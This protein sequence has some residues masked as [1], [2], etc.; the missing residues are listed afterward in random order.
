M[1]TGLIEAVGTLVEV[2]AYGGGLRLRIETPFAREMAPGHSLAV[3]GVCLTATLIDGDEVH[4]DVGPETARVTTLADLTR[5]QMVNLERS[6][7]A[8]GRIGGHFVQGHVDGVGTI[9]EVRADGVSHWLTVSYPPVLAPYLV[10]RGAVAVDGISLTIA[11]LGDRQFD[12]QVVP[13]TWANTTLQTRRAGDRVNIECDMLGKYIVRTVDL[14]GR[15]E[16]A[17]R[18]L[19]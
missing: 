9:D 14:A 17:R 16:G 18:P 10:H 7:R 2:K 13:H 3:N 1:F 19:A 15:G 11:G 12:I 8:D 4:A 5:G 6:L